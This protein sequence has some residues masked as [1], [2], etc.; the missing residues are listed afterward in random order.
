[1]TK[2]GMQIVTSALRELGIL[3]MV[4]TASGDRLDDGID[5]A[6]GLLDSWRLERLLIPGITISLYNLA[7]GTQTYTIGTGGTFNQTYPTSIECWSV[8]PDGSATNPVEH[9]MGRPLTSDQWQAI[10]VKSSTGSYPTS[11]YYDHSYAAGLGTVL[12]HPIPNSNLPDVKL[13]ARVPALTALVAATSYDLAPGVHR[14]LILNLAM[15]LVDRYGS[16]AIVSP[17]LDKRATTSLAAIKRANIVPK[18]SPI[19]SE[20]VIGSEAGRRNFNV[21][22]GA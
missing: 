18:E 9:P 20:F 5:A 4:Q 22:T 6:C 10:R 12:V 17:N 11:L 21:Y 19:R 2:T 7:S 16:A 13:Y 14:A 8:I 3:G 15:E 1:M